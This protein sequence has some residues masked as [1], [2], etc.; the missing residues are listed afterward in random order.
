MQS[1]DELLVARA[2]AG[3]RS[4]FGELTERHRPKVTRLATRLT[5]GHAAAADCTQATFLRAWERIGQLRDN[6]RFAPWLMSICR[7]VAANMRRADGVR[8][9]HEAAAPDAAHRAFDI[10]RWIEKLTV[11][12]AVAE[13]PEPY[14]A[15]VTRFYFEGFSQREIADDLGVPVGTLKSRLHYARLKLKEILSETMEPKMP[16][17]DNLMEAFM[18]KAEPEPTL[19]YEELANETL[20]HFNLGELRRV[21]SVYR[22]SDSVGIAIETDRGRYR[23]W[24]YQPWMTRELVDLQHQALRHLAEKGVPVK[25]LIPGSSG[26]TAFAIDNHLVAMF[27]W[28][29]GSGVFDLLRW[30]DTLEALGDLHGRWVAAMTDFSPGV[31]DWQ[32]LASSWRPRKG[33]ALSLPFYDLPDVPARMGLFRAAREM[34]DPPPYHDEFLRGIDDTERRLERFAE[35]V[36]ALRMRD[37]PHGLNHGVLLFGLQDF[38]LMVTDA[39]DFIYEPRIGD[40]GRLLWVLL[41][42]VGGP[43]DQ[44]HKRLRSAI[45][46]FRRHVDPS[47]DELRSLPCVALSFPLFYRVFHVLLYLAE[48]KAGPEQARYLLDS[49]VDHNA[50]LDVHEADID[51]LTGALLAE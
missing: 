46:A 21:G 10:D 18:E 31:A 32:E 11:R 27:E 30:P 14:R 22:P 26:E 7:S 37:L 4:A 12:D 24:R 8:E 28:F 2:R 49:L 41:H 51:R 5:N 38:D 3:D 44:R 17:F 45:A 33:W 36:E 19:S 47:E 9:S 42:D 39:D 34:D 13:L 25:R 29:G 35:Q 43:Q 23:L 15:P 40:L 48:A 20:K 6:G 16:R 50:K 1:E